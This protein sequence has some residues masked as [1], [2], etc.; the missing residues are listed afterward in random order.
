ME[1]R[2]HKFN[3][4]EL[5][6]TV[7]WSEDNSSAWDGFRTA[8]LF[9]CKVK[10]PG[11]TPYM[12][13]EWKSTKKKQRNLLPYW[14]LYITFPSMHRC[15]FSSCTT[16]ESDL[17]GFH[18]KNGPI[19]FLLCTLQLLR[20]SRIYLRQ[21]APVFAASLPSCLLLQPHQGCFWQSTE[22][23][24]NLHLVGCL[25]WPCCQLLFFLCS[26]SYCEFYLNACL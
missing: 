21:T 3:S 24:L 10:H 13:S 14:H 12:R 26:P 7:K 8:T 11:W 25:Q 6:K 20:I 15:G 17:A 23:L 19:I 5:Q 4:I 18:P 1:V 2:L 9:G 22:A 16:M